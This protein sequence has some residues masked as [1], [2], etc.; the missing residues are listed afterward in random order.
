VSGWAD[1]DGELDL[2]AAQ[3]REATLWWRD[4]D[5]TRDTPALRRLLACAS[6]SGVPVAVAVIPATLESNCVDVVKA[7][8][9]ATVVQH[10]Y[11]HRNHAPPGERNWELGAH[12]PLATCVEELAAGSRTLVQAFGERFVAALVPPWNRIDDAVARALPEAGLR[13]LSTFGP[14]PSREAAA[15]VT[16]VN[17]HVDLIA[18]RHGRTFIGEQRGVSR[19]VEHLSARREQRVDA[20]EPTGLLTH[21]LDHDEALWAFVDALFACTRRHAAARWLAAGEVFGLTGAR[22]A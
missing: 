9:I 21:H 3:G 16:L 8:P 2:W 7:S 4:D 11:A 22:S 14:R 10:G 13:A 19:L 20:G 12:R 5:A 15:D 18:W 17:T 6:A 1:L